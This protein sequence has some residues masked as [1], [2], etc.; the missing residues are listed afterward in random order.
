MV[1]DALAMQETPCATKAWASMIL[2][3]WSRLV[4]VI[5]ENGFRLLGPYH[6]GRMIEIVNACLHLSWKKIHVKD[7]I[8][9]ELEELFLRRDNGVICVF[10]ASVSCTGLS[11][12]KTDMW[13][14]ILIIV[15]V[16]IFPNLFWNFLKRVDHNLS[17][18]AVNNLEK[19]ISTNFQLKMWLP[20]SG[21]FSLIV[22]WQCDQSALVVY[23]MKTISANVVSG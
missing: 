15:F 21:S 10:Y 2:N 14:R 4:L 23:E 18:K 7:S 22:V 8:S 13:F 19:L 20:R 9:Y 3:M 12:C 5:H 1:T 6:Y 11:V 16:D 17:I